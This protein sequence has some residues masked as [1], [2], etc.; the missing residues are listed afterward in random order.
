LRIVTVRRISQV[1]FV[2]A[3]L[4]FCIVSTLGRDFMQLRGWPVNLILEMDPLVAIGTA[5]STHT[6][7]RGLIRALPVIILTILFG[8]FFC[9]WVCPFGAMHQ[10]VGWLGNHG[11]KMPDRISRNRFRKTQVLK[12]I[13]LLVFLVMAFSLPGKIGSL[14]TGL[15]DPI[16]LVYRSW[17]IAILPILDRDVNIMNV[18]PRYY[19]GAWLI[20]AVFVA[21]I[22]LNLLI[23]RFYCRFLCPLG[24]L[25]GLLG[26]YSLW[27]I[28]KT[29]AACSNCGICER[30]CEGACRPSGKLRP[31]E[32]V[33]CMNCL[34]VCPEDLVKY[35]TKPSAAGEET[36]TDVG[37]R[38]FLATLATGLVAVPL[39]RL[40]G[41]L[42]TNWRPSILRPPGALPEEE[43]LKRCIKCG[44]CMRACPTNIIVPGGLD[45][46]MENLWTPVLNFRSGTSGCQLTCT[47]CGYMC[48]TAAIRPITLSEKL[49]VNEFAASGPVRIGTAFVD[50]TRCLPWAMNTP[51][52]VCQE[53]CPVTPKAIYIEDAYE[54]VRDGAFE[55]SEVQGADVVLRNARMKPE[56][57]ATGDYF[58]AYNGR[59]FRILA[60]TET[61]L[62]LET[63]EGNDPIPGAGGIVEVQAFLQRPRVEVSRCI[64]CGTCEHECPVSGLR[65]IRIT[66][67]NESRDAGHSLLIKRG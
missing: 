30:A 56:A 36:V 60:N 54:T 58:C 15:L 65:A 34:H 66:A 5:L 44:Q 48:P 46:G 18:T 47:A 29:Q 33:L 12:Y 37:R 32:C 45:G 63:A 20:G 22:L 21:A 39:I 14:Q 40:G 49:G 61:T 64:G 41:T 8:R 52:I 62:T 24:A 3:F 53:N 19:E 9:G 57:F 31:M 26:R 7:Y 4:W 1:F 27:R 42:G 13:L 50:R 6:I 28:A 59:K 43:F 67:E 35:G 11:R 23:P 16:P 17:N 2:V 51:C 10:F 25:L 55:V 38:G